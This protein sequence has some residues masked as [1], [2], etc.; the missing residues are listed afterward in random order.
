MEA[1]LTI[2]LPDGTTKTIQLKDVT[3]STTY[4]TDIQP[5]GQTFIVARLNLSAVLVD[6]TP[7][8]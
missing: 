5:V 8:S 2:K 1:E 7:T 3:Y 6:S 4:G